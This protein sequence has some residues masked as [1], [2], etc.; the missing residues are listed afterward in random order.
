MDGKSV[1]EMSTKQRRYHSLT[2]RTVRATM[3]GCVL[4][5]VIS[6]IIGVWFYGLAM[7]QQHIN[8]ASNIAS[9]ASMSVSHGSADSRGF[10]RQ[11]MDIYRGL[12]EEQR[13]KVGTDEYRAYFADVDMSKGSDYDI[14][15]NMLFTFQR[16]GEVDYV[17][18]GMYD[19]ATGALVYFVDPDEGERMYPGDWETVAAREVQTFLRWDGEG[20][21]YDI[22]RTPKYGW[23]CTAGVPITSREDG[24]VLLFV[25]ADV[26]INSVLPAMGAFSLQL[27]IALAAATLL[28]AWVQTRRMKRAIVAP[29]NAIAGAAEDYVR[30]KRA[31]VADTAHF[32]SLDI[33]SHDEVENLGLVM[34]DMERDLASYEEDLTRITAEKERISAE[35]SLATRIQASM[36]PHIFPPFPD[37]TEFDIYATMDPAKEVGG[38]F[39]DF[40]LIDDDHLGL[41]MADVSGKGV[42]AA[43]FMMASKIILQSCAMLGQSAGEILTKTNEAVCSNNQEEMF[44]TVWMGILQISAG[45]LTAANAGHEYPAIRRA[46]GSFELF[47]DKHG[48][49]I[50]GLPGA[51]YKEYELQ[52]EPGD[53]L[54]VY[55]D[56]VPEATNSDEQLFGTERMLA[57]LNDAADGPEQVLRNVRRAVD[58]FVGGAEQF[59]DLTMMCLEYHGGVK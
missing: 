18:L 26:T 48:F 39:Y 24:S 5:G 9:Y 51:R 37:R 44:I 49:V 34:A 23:M 47:H 32:A 45:I 20:K 46:N 31:G 15:M 54:F 57:A 58:A 19:E 53:K 10:A 11:V 33:H 55:T 3:M 50:G 1:R 25:L 21:L 22:D 40:F 6:L 8:L 27:I 13:Q 4:L 2:R 12:S 7:V 38:D 30:D 16:A 41:V 17:Y 35:L 28:I 42:P 59:D 29:I 36:M 52:L 43:L 14:M 56:G